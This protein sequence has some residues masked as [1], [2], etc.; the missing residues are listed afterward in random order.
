MRGKGTLFCAATR[1]PAPHAQDRPVHASPHHPLISSSAIL[2]PSPGRPIVSKMNFKRLAKHA[3]AAFTSSSRQF[4]PHFI[5]FAK[6]P[7]VCKCDLA[8]LDRV[9]FSPPP[10]PRPEPCHAKCSAPTRSFEKRLACIGC[11]AL[12]FVSRAGRKCFNVLHVCR[13]SASISRVYLLRIR[14]LVYAMRMV[15]FLR[16]CL[17]YNSLRNLLSSAKRCGTSH[18]LR[19]CPH[20]FPTA[21]CE[22]HP[23]SMVFKSSS[24][25]SRKCNAKDP[26]PPCWL[27]LGQI[28]R[29]VPHCQ[30]RS[31]PGLADADVIFTS[32]IA[33]KPPEFL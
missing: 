4:D 26:P 31:P 33:G 18:H 7:S 24:P 2:D 21:P 29:C 30:N 5:W 20:S 16:T 1:S 27:F 22:M 9:S 15:C 10:A 25:A 8:D 11:L 32:T 14:G 6:A 19:Q 12:A 3:A 28:Q 23:W 17:T 13:S